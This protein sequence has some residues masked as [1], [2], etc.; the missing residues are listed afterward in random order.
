MEKVMPVWDMLLVHSLRPL[1]SYRAGLQLLSS[2]IYREIVVILRCGRNTTRGLIA[3]DT[4]RLSRILVGNV[5]D[6]AYGIR[7][8]QFRS[9]KSQS[10]NSRRSSGKYN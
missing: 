6:C 8:Y 7:F 10:S 3:R 4:Q 5:I 1:F 2:V 9:T